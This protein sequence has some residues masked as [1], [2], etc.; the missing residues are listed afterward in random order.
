VVQENT[1]IAGSLDGE[2]GHVAEVVSNA[3]V[4][5]IKDLFGEADDR[6]SSREP[7]P[8]FPD[9]QLPAVPGRAPP[10]PSSY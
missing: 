3:A 8:E 1:V 9:V 7:L 5:G 6:I 2:W 10:P 4:R